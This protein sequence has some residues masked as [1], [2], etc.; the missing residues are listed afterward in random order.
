MQNSKPVAT[1]IERNVYGEDKTEPFDDTQYRE[2]IG[3]IMYVSQGSRPDVTFAVSFLSRFM[4][5]PTVNLWSNAKRILRYLNATQD[6]G[7]HYDGGVDGTFEY[8]CD[9]DY[10]SCPK[11]RKSTSGMI[12]VANGS[13]I[14][15]ASQKQPT[16]ALSTCEAETIAAAEFA[17]V[18]IWFQRLVSELGYG[19]MPIIRIDNQA[20][21]KLLRESQLSRRSRHMDVRHFFIREKIEAKILDISYV[22]SE[23]N[24][25]DILTKPMNKSV[26]QR[27]RDSAGI[28]CVSPKK[29]APK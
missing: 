6:Y 12:I 20:S 19:K 5:C 27:L 11:T 14:F 8:Y 1:P 29:N 21:I 18:V 25:S 23:S 9:S 22:P 10:A 26:F 13:P 15:W 17:K 2:L 16:I 3:S 28:R 24:L 7:I 4:H